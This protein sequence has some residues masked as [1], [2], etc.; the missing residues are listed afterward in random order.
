MKKSLLNYVLIEGALILRQNF[1]T[2]SKSNIVFEH[3]ELIT[4]AQRAFQAQ[5]INIED[6]KLI[7]EHLVLA[8][9]RS[10]EG[11]GVS[12]IPIY[13]NRLKVGVVNSCPRISIDKK[14][15]SV[16]IINGDNGM[17]FVVASLGMKQSIDMAE[18]QGI[19]LVGI[20]NSNHFGASAGYILQALE[21]N[22]ISIILTNS[23]P[24][25]PPWGSTNPLLGA[26][27]IA[28]GA[29][30]G[31]HFPFLLDMATS[32]VSRGKLRLAHQ[33]GVNLYIYNIL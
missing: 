12:R 19:G 29:P 26:S 31:S 13:I 2:Q 1:A 24:A 20:N 21:E 17:G 4:F 25:Q 18:S 14:S 23:S 8:D 33:R 30:S 27:P 6:S 15:E 11:H 32:A 9:L 22:L 5:K 16:Q 10:Q 3:T 28:A 7:A